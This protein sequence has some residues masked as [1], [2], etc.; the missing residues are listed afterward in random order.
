MIV[1]EQSPQTAVT[2]APGAPAIGLWELLAAATC[3]SVY[4]LDGFDILMMS[5]AAPSIGKALS[6]SAAQTGL[7]F[8]SGLAGMMIGALSLAPLSDRIG[9]RT[10]IIICL[11]INIVGMFATGWSHS[12]VQLLV[13]RFITGLGVGGMMPVANTALAEIVDESRRNL[14]IIVQS[15]AYPAGGLLAALGWPVMIQQ[16]TWHEVLQAA[17]LPSIACLG[18]VLALLPETVPFLLSRRPAG[19]LRRAN[20]TL[21]RFG[22]PL[23]AELPVPERLSAGPAGGSGFHGTVRRNLIA[24][25]GVVFLA[26]FSFYFFVSWLPTVM[27]SSLANAHASGAI[28]LNLGGIAGLFVLAGLSVC[29]PTRRLTAATML[30]GF[31]SVAALAF[32]LDKAILTLM[33]AGLVGAALFALMAGIYSIAPVVF[34]TLNRAG[35]LGIA[36]SVGRFG[37]VLSPWLGALLLRL[38]G[39]TLEATLL[40]MAVPLVGAAV[41]LLFLQPLQP[42]LRSQRG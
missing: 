6:L 37:G 25:S 8:S 12:L 11:A 17:C 14:A 16:Y 7:M 38:P 24:L 33:L 31:A 3:V 2:R 15:A 42:T 20:Q 5:V 26:Q 9:R 10:A 18:L 32:C 13:F 19:A 29:V 30:L 34:P 21:R 41:T 28:L 36:F 40:V 23:L 35:G 39:V 1:T 4:L 27:E 22:Q